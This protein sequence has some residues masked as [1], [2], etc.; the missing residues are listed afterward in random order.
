MFLR[1]VNGMNTRTRGLLAKSALF[2]ATLIWGISFVV[3]KNTLDN[4]PAFYLLAFRFSTAAVIL[5]LVFIKSFSSFNRDYLIKGSILGAL[6]FCAY[7]FQTIGLESTTPG[8]NAFLTAV[9][10]VMVPFL[11]WGYSK[12]RPNAFNIS[13]SIIC[14]IG[15][16][17]VSLN[18]G[19][20]MGIGDALT[21]VCGLFYAMHIVAVSSFSQGRD[22]FLLTII[23]FASSALLGWLFGL[24]FDSFPKSISEGS[25][26]S[27]LYLSV[28]ATAVALLLQNVGQKYTP[29]STAGI[30]LSLESVFGVLFS[31][32]FYHEALILKT[33]I[34]FVLIFIAV[35]VSETRLEF[36]KRNKL[37]QTRNQTN[38]F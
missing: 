26:F 37:I 8:K 36:L 2:G 16:G 29:A 33:F 32:I 11:Y 15:I 19:L 17:L 3:M 30:I 1:E 25:L 34:G 5:S 23:Q 14:I 28:F 20:T 24:G 7:G 10:C 13:A 18:E 4:V 27:L 31:I 22:I 38:C 35:I 21:L 6:L 9:Y 12:R